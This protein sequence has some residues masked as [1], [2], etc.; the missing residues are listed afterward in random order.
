MTGLVIWLT[1]QLT[2]P[3]YVINAEALQTAETAD[4][5]VIQKDSK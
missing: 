2:V 4:N 1:Q 5:Q 3:L